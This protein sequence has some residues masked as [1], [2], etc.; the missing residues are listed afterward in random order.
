MS[1]VPITTNRWT[2]PSAT[3]TR[4]PRWSRSASP[5]PAPP[6]T[7]DNASTSNLTATRKTRDA[8]RATAAGTCP[9]QTTSGGRDPGA[10][11]VQQIYKYGNNAS[12]VV[13]SSDLLCLFVLFLE[14]EYVF[15]KFFT[16]RVSCQVSFPPSG[17]ILPCT[18]CSDGGDV[19]LL[20]LS[21]CCPPS[22]GEHRMRSPPSCTHT[23]TQRGCVFLTRCRARVVLWS[24]LCCSAL[25]TDGFHL[26]NLVLSST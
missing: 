22:H 3:P 18:L 17:C 6:S 15:F 11:Y 8:I 21:L 7:A 20:G 12:K 5:P 10:Q 25:E 1:T 4:S 26:F 24:R 23:H 2:N 14:V 16:A 13:C 9:R 19:W